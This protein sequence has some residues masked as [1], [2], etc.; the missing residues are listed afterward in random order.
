MS[1]KA[2]ALQLTCQTVNACQTREEAE[3]KML[4]TIQRIERQI[5]ASLTAIGRETLLVVVPEYFLTGPP[6]DE[7]VEQ[8]VDK[9]ALEID[10]R[11][12]EAMS[13]M[14]QRQQVYFSGNVYE[15]DPFFPELYFQ[16]SF[17][18]GPNGDVL[19]RYRR[20]NTLFT[21]TPHD[22]WELYLD[23]YGYDSLFPVAKTNIGNL[24]CIAS[25]DILYPE[26]AR[27]LTMQGAEVLIHSSSE[28][29][30]PLPTAKAIAKQARAIENMAYVVSA[31]SAGLV[32][33]SLPG[34]TIDGG[35][36]IIDPK[37]L[38]LAKAGS[39]ESLVA[40]ADIDLAALRE[41]RQRPS[42]SNLLARQRTE[43]YAGSYAKHSAYPPGTLL[44]QPAERQ[45]FIRT[46]QEV[47]KKLYN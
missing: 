45:H 11:L 16:T 5:A 9:A 37:G 6:E 33:S 14:V 47:I 35:S 21:P 7:T 41:F 27:C 32:G 23:A 28:L 3:A 13:A 15:Q 42:A 34:N 8:W 10:G 31:N 39:G 17:I 22:V 26:V 36:S 24:A 1:Y 2:L 44:S 12:Y 38:I 18:M 46:Q 40:N 30:S 29:N 43:L 20:L 25:D 4:E 19:L